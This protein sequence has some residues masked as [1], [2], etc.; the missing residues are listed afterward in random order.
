MEIEETVGS[1]KIVRILGLICQFASRSSHVQPG[2]IL[3]NVEVLEHN[4]E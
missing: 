2:G 1:L 4:F 3:T